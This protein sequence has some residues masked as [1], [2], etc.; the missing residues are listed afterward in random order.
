VLVTHDTYDVVDA[1]AIPWLT[2]DQMIEADRLAIEVFNIE[3]LQMM[4]HAGAGL[5]R[6]T[7]EIAPPGPVRSVVM[8]A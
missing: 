7:D 8:Q 5:A 2:V 4:E 3:L 6:L 1:D